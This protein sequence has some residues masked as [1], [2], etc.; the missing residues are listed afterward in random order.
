MTNNFYYKICGMTEISNGKPSV[1]GCTK[2][3][4]HTFVK[5]ISKHT[6]GCLTFGILF[7]TS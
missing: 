1:S 6:E 2:S 3:S 7:K 5:K 4:S